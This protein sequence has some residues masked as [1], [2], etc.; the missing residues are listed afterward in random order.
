M[1]KIGAFTSNIRGKDQRSDTLDDTKKNLDPLTR[2]YQTPC[3][4]FDFVFGSS[5]G[6]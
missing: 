1:L 4:S 2:K 3:V 5:S 6:G